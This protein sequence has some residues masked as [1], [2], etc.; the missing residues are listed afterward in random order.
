MIRLTKNGFKYFEFDDDG[1]VFES[2]I[3]SI[4]IKFREEFEI[5]TDVTLADLYKAIESDEEMA[6]LVDKIFPYY[7]TKGQT[8]PAIATRQWV[9]ED[10]GDGFTEFNEHSYRVKSP[11]IP[12]PESALVKIDKD[13][14]IFHRTSETTKT[15]GV[16]KNAS[17]SLFE[18]LSNLFNVSPPQDTP[19]V[20]IT[21]TSFQTRPHKMVGYDLNNDDVYQF[22]NQ[23]CVIEDGVTLKDIF[24]IMKQNEG[25][26]EF[27]RRF[28]WCPAMDEF[29]DL[30]KKEAG[31]DNII[32][33]CLE[34]SSMASLFDGY[35]DSETSFHGLDAKGDRE[36]ISFLPVNDIANLPIK[37]NNSFKLRY[38][39]GTEDLSGDRSITLLEILD[40]IY[41]EI[42]FW[43]T[44]KTI[45]QTL[46]LIRRKLQNTEET[47]E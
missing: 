20:A 5:D 12:P 41:W 36:S 10:I 21:K 27:F 13:V 8:D 24:D 39:T 33:A 43:G 38:D 45:P 25:L 40:A 34:I 23:S 42:S 11:T 35:L 28:S 4:V 7:R 18:V 22:L 16:G 2:P 15:I 46:E 6:W 3:D 37:L 9:F 14:Q 32:P 17:W 31:V 30:A 26:M 1:T 29:H 47:N 44:P 19:C